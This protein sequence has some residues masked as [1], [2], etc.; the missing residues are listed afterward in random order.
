[1]I[2]FIGSLLG[3]GGIAGVALHFFGFAGLKKAAGQLPAK[4]W[5]IIGIALAL[6]AAFFAHQHY[7]HA[8]IAAAEQ[9]GY[10]RAIAD[11]KAQQKRVDA[12]ARERKARIEAAATNITQKTEVHLEKTVT[13][14]AGDARA[15]RVRGAPASGSIRVT[16][17]GVLGLPGAAGG[18]DGAAQGALSGLAEIPWIPLVDHGELCDVDRAKLGALQ[19]WIR[20]QQ[21]LH[22]GGNNNGK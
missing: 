9:R 22:N 3:V 4:D 12:R 11:V 5:L 17:G 1:M 13:D 8:A 7:A 20:E 10:D 18:R 15:L 6:G 21:Q 14:I 2:A 16:G 19:G